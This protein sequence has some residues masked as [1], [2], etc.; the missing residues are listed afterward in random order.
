MTAQTDRQKRIDEFG[1]LF[2]LLPGPK[3][4]DRIRQTQRAM[5]L[6]NEQHVRKYIMAAPARAPSWQGLRMLRAWV[7]RGGS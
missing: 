3:K 6:A 2:A 1:A 5:G 7:E 4:V